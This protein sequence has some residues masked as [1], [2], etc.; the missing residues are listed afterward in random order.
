[1]ILILVVASMNYNK[2]GAFCNPHF[3]GLNLEW[4]KMIN[5]TFHWCKSKFNS[6]PPN[7]DCCAIKRAT[8]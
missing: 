4:L 3:F 5:N 2:S 8:P 7:E 6:T 1:M